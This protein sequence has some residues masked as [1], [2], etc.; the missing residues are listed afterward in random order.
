[1]AHLLV[2]IQHAHHFR[3]KDRKAL[4]L[5]RFSDLLQELYLFNE[6]RGRTVR[7]LGRNGVNLNI[8]ER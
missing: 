6:G 3:F 8:P 1:M 2:A 4:R 5:E 7:D